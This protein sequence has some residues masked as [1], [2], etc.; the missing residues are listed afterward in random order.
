MTRGCY[1]DSTNEKS[2]CITLGSNCVRCAPEATGCNSQ[3]ALNTAQLS[4]VHCTGNEECAWG[5][6]GANATRCTQDVP[7]YQHESCFTYSHSNRQVTRGCTAEYSALCISN[8]GNCIQC[9]ANGCNVQNIDTQF[10]KRCKSD[11]EGQESCEEEKPL[12]FTEQC[13]SSILEYKD[14]GCY[15]RNIGEG[16]IERGCGIDLTAEQLGECTNDEYESCDYCVGEI[17][18]DGPPPS[19]AYYIRAL[20]VLSISAIFAVV[21]LLI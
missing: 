13:T 10:C 18:N 9:A 11:V 17:C 12:E 3:A 21:H 5:Y 14:R 8:D 20:S 1:S 19:A 16:I 2:T 7:F 4:C 15:T 6:T